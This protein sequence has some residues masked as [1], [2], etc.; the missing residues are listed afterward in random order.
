MNHTSRSITSQKIHQPECIPQNPPECIVY[1]SIVS[2]SHPCRASTGHGDCPAWNVR[3]AHPAK[4]SHDIVVGG[5]LGYVSGGELELRA[6]E[7]HRFQQ[8]FDSARQLSC[9]PR[10]ASQPIALAM[11]PHQPFTLEIQPL[12]IFG[13]DEGLQLAAEC[14]RE[15]EPGR[16][17][18][19]EVADRG[20]K[21]VRCRPRGRCRW[22][23]SPRRLDRLR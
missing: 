22:P 2:S 4:D 8:L 9:H 17:P 21:G 10:L 6:P 15:P 3:P 16:K 19:R 13:A 11:E 18:L 23:R 7:P 12:R 5:S 1:Q 14:P 20:P